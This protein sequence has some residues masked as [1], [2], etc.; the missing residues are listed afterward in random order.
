MSVRAS[1]ALI[2]GAL[3]VGPAWAAERTGMA[4]PPSRATGDIPL[5][6]EVRLGG[7]DTQTRLVVDLSQKID[8][9]AFTLAN[10]YRVVIDLPQVTFQFPPKTGDRGRGLIKAFRFGLVMPGGSRI[11]LDAAGPVRVEKAFV[12]DPSDSQPPP[13]VLDLLTADRD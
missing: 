8:T 6:T 2:F 13:L 1:L 9:R 10:P 5:A 4:A 12:L 11:V 3:L 7:D